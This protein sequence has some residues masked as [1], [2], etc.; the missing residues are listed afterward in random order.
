VG[1][2]RT[3]GGLLPGVPIVYSAALKSL[4][5][6]V[7]LASR[8]RPW[9]V[10]LNDAR[11]QDPGPARAGE[12]EIAPQ[13]PLA[14]ELTGHLRCVRCGYDLQGLSVRANCSE[15]GLSV[16]A[17]LLA[18]VD[19]H[20]D[21]LQP[22]ILPLPTAVGLVLWPLGAIFAAAVIWAVRARDAVALLANIEPTLPWAPRAV[23][24]GVI[25]S[26]LGAL[27]LIRP[28]RVQS[29]VT[30][31]SAFAAVLLY[32]PL[33]WL[34]QRTLEHDSPLLAKP[35]LQPDGLTFPRVLMAMAAFVLMAMIA[36]GLRASQQL[37]VARSVLMRTGRA[38]R[39]KTPGLLAA[40]AMI[41]VGQVFHLACFWMGNDVR[42]E[43]VDI[44][45]YLGTMLVAVGSMLF[46]LGLIGLLLD[47]LRLWP[48]VTSRPLSIQD[49][50][51]DPPRQQSS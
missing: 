25:I 9:V 34:M 39:Q 51:G 31:L 16:R 35:Y 40:L 30:S 42:P 23:A 41:L 17:T 11:S 2:I 18:K 33:A 20:A 44:P 3:L 50:L 12:P 19:P 28:H 22:I 13:S 7:L 1:S 21:E 24:A 43:Y 6:L 49:V 38:E 4:P 48:V 10:L 47:S 36:Q 37:L 32:L 26:G 15:C 5:S 45:R 14:R 46:T 29:A 8:G 27:A